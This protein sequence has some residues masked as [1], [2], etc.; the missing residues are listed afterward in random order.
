M[1]I[2]CMHLDPWSRDFKNILVNEMDEVPETLIFM[3]RIMVRYE[4]RKTKWTVAV[5]KTHLIV[6]VLQSL[7][8]PIF[9]TVLCDI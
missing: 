3:Q 8:H 7:L 1:A 6:T 5:K 4:K 9:S 2:L